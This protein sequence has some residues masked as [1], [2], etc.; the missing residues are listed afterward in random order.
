M[1]THTTWLHDALDS[2]LCFIIIASHEA[3]SAAKKYLRKLIVTIVV[4]H[5]K[6]I[7]LGYRPHIKAIQCHVIPRVVHIQLYLALAQF[8][9]NREKASDLL[10]DENGQEEIFRIWLNKSPRTWENLLKLLHKLNEHQLADEL[11]D[12]LERKGNHLFNSN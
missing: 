9:I 5:Y 7:Y 11:Q 10:K 6:Y 8:G 4:N 1:C 2:I 3:D 12:K